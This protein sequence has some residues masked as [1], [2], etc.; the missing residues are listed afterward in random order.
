ME[1]GPA[2]QQLR[3]NDARDDA[4]KTRLFMSVWSYL[5]HPL[6]R[7]ASR[8]QC[9]YS[10]GWGLSLS[11]TSSHCPVPFKSSP[12]APAVAYTEPGTRPTSISSGGDGLERESAYP[13]MLTTQ[14]LTQDIRNTM[15]K[16]HVLLR[17][18]HLRPPSAVAGPAD[19][20]TV[21]S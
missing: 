10:L 1:N 16:T 11:P 14:H 18:P 15:F 17:F 19:T 21:S 7:F 3:F 4:A 12:W 8:T 9:H 6:T 5:Y 2:G 13:T 20:T